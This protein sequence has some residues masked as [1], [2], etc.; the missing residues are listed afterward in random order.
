MTGFTGCQHIVFSRQGRVLTITLNRPAQRNAANA[1]LHA[2]W[3]PCSPTPSAMPAA[4]G[5]EPHRSDA[6]PRP[7]YGSADQQVTD[8]TPARRPAG[9]CCIPKS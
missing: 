8:V 6:A 1:C 3:P 4:M 5:S 7:V 2:G 9:L